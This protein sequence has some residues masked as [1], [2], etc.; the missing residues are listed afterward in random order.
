MRQLLSDFRKA[1][2]NEGNLM[3]RVINLEQKPG[4]T[5]R[6]RVKRRTEQSAQEAP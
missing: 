4:P 1:L 5:C 2:Q 6:N 3:P